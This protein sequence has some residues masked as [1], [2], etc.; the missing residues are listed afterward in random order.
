MYRISVITCSVRN[1]G[2]GI[3]RNVWIDV[4]SPAVRIAHWGTFVTTPFVSDENATVA[5]EISVENEGVV[6]EQDVVVETK[7]F[8]PS[9]RHVATLESRRLSN[10]GANSTIVVVQTGVLLRP[11]RWSLD[12]PDLYTA[13]TTLST[14]QDGEI[15]RYVTPFGIRS[16]RYS[17]SAGFE[18]NGRHVSIRGV[19]L[20][21]DLGLLGAAVSARAIERRL[22][23][24]RAMG[25]NAIR[26]S[27]NPPSPEMLSLCDRMGFLVMLE[28]LDEWRLHKVRNGYAQHFDEWHERDVRAAMLSSR[29]SPSIFMWSIGNEVK[30]Q[31]NATL[32]AQTARQLVRL[33]KRYDA[34]RAVTCAINDLNAVESLGAELDVVGL[35]YKPL[36]YLEIIK[37]HPNWMLIATET[38]STVSSRGIYHLP[39]AK[40]Q[41]HE[42]LEITS[43][44]IIGLLSAVLF[45]FFVVVLFFDRELEKVLPGR[46]HPT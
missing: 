26:T 45:L 3:Y 39:L 6:A 44:D 38:A 34:T 19:C 29:N 30:E 41:L 42:S 22:T 16:L 12:S 7:L 21:H 4:F 37:K 5:I 35:N 1:L 43:Y 27:H 13:V 23:L 20:H 8:D 31:A 11:F 32:A 24:L 18:L 14:E 46:T 40:Y 15:D 2:V 9:H 33:V 17:A 28:F 36:N 25:A 10:V